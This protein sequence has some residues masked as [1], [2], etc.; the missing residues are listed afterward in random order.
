MELGSVMVIE[1]GLKSQMGYQCHGLGKKD[2]PFDT[3]FLLNP[4]KQ[5]PSP[6]T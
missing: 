1:L 5:A 6:N 3:N 4:I 2:Y